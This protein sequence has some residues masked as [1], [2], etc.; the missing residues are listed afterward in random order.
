ME[1]LIKCNNCGLLWKQNCNMDEHKDMRKGNYNFIGNDSCCPLC[2][3]NLSQIDII[4]KNK[5]WNGGTFESPESHETHK[6]IIYNT[7]NKLKKILIN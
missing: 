7:I 2:E 3:S 1:L 5:V 6:N 4:H